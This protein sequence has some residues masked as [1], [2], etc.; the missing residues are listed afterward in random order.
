MND[1]LHGVF[2]VLFPLILTNVLHLIVIK[3]NLFQF[4]CIPVNL[5]LFGENKTWR[6]FIFV[7]FTNSIILFLFDK[8][9]SLQVELP[10]LI[11][12]I[13]GLSYVLFELPNSFLKR[14]AGISP[15]KSH[16]SANYFYSVLDKTDSAFGVTAAYYFL[17]NIS[18]A[19]AI[20]LFLTN[21][22]IHLLLAFVLVRVKLKSSI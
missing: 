20:V 2:V 7:S 4:V 19:V 14:R 8:L 11:G 10:L 16:L 6:G 3:L 12:F 1:F 13:L 22:L 9:F 21:S 5:K 17:S 18:I 15:G